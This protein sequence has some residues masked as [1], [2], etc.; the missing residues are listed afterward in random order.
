VINI[1]T[2]ALTEK[3]YVTPPDKVD[4][5]KTLALPAPP[6]IKVPL[7]DERYANLECK[8]VDGKMVTNTTSSS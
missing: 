1:P 8:V 4:K 3:V 5:F 2:V 7:I 6:V